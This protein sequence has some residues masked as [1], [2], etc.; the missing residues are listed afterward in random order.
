M[1]WFFFFFFFSSRRRH[2]RL[3]SDWSSDVCS[4]DLPQSVITTE[5]FARRHHLHVNDAL[6]LGIGDERRSF[7]IRGLLRNEGP[8]R[9]LD[10]NFVLMDIAAAQWAFDRLGRVDRVEIRLPPGRDVARS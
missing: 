5:I 8:A 3:V 7:V 9:V 2:T 4:S 1:F 6:E 10:G